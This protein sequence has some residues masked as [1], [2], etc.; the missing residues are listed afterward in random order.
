[1]TN[2]S[3]STEMILYGNGSLKSS[4]ASLS[5]QSSMDLFSVY[6]VVFHL[7]SKRWTRSETSTDKEIFLIM[8]L[9]VTCCG[10][11]LQMMERK[12]SILHLEEP[13]TAGEMT[14]VTSSATQMTSKWSAELISSS[15]TDTHM[16]TRR[17]VWLSFLLPITATV[18][19][20]RLLLLKLEII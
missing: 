1:M 9:F 8:D 10:L 18:V 16:L 13:V 14:S 11:T 17:N 6:M 12:V 4:S 20:T 5:L 2:A 15:W 3:E 7:K 19:A